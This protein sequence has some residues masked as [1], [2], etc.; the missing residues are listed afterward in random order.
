MYS[1]SEVFSYMHTDGNLYERTTHTCH[2]T[3]PRARTPELLFGIRVEVACH[4]DHFTHFLPSALEANKATEL[5]RKSYR[6]REKKLQNSQEKSRTGFQPFNLLF[7]VAVAEKEAAL[8]VPYIDDIQ[9]EGLSD[10]G[11]CTGPQ[12]NHP[13]VRHRHRSATVL[14]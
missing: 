14:S 8:F 9:P 5:A 2:A 1:W 7:R 6:T 10:I 3:A 4:T 11:H 12:S 13:H